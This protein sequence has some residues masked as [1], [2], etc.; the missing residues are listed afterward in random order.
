ML[1]MGGDT[2]MNAIADPL[3]DEKIVTAGSDDQACLDK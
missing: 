3:G 2:D 1:V